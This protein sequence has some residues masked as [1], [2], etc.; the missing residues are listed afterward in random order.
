MVDD[1]SKSIDDL[2]SQKA[3]GQDTEATPEVAPVTPADVEA[4]PE[5]PADP[6]PE[7]AKTLAEKIGADKE[8]LPIEGEGPK[9][10]PA[11]VQAQTQPPADDTGSKS[12]V[13]SGDVDLKHIKTLPQEQ[14]VQVLTE[15][16]MSDGLDKA[17]S[18]VRALKDPYLFDLLHD[19]LVDKLFDRLKG[20]KLKK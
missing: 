14:Q 5:Q 11:S 13:V 4:K 8:E 7:K 2:I 20:P 12:A 9:A 15:M 18:I 6:G 16:V 1:A 3:P 19:T 10:T 17:I